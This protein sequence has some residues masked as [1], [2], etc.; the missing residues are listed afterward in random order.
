MSVSNFFQWGIS[1]SF[2]RLHARFNIESVWKLFIY[3]CVSKTKVK[4][5]TTVKC[6]TRFVL[7]S[8][9]MKKCCLMVRLQLKFP[10]S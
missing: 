10:L 8:W 6:F 9:K 3:I 7:H 4:M 5:E 1:F 2:V